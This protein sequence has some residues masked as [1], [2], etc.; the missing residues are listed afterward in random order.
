LPPGVEG[1]AGHTQLLAQP[2][3]R[4]ALRQ[5]LDQAKPLGGSCSTA[6]QKLCG[7]CQGA[8]PPA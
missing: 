8:L 7:L 6:P 2:G 5:S 3:H 4:K 1:A